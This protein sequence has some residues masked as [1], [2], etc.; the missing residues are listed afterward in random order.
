MTV[1]TK[2]LAQP[3][4]QPPSP[5][6]TR[7]VRFSRFLL[8]YFSKTNSSTLHAAGAHPALYTSWTLEVTQHMMGFLLLD[9]G[10]SSSVVPWLNI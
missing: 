10:G 9:T 8:S 4:S 1:I 3:R 5:E 7:S 2:S 6:V